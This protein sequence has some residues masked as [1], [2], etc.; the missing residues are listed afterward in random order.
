MTMFDLRVGKY[1]LLKKKVPVQDYSELSGKLEA[2]RA[3]CRKEEGK[4]VKV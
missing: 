2:T 1:E 3:L 4:K